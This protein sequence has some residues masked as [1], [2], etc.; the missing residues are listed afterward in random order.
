MVSGKHSMAAS[1]P[2]QTGVR[3][4][5]ALRALLRLPLRALY[6]QPPAGR[7]TTSAGPPRMAT[8]SIRPGAEGNYAPRLGPVDDLVAESRLSQLRRISCGRR[9]RSHGLGLDTWRVSRMADAT[10]I[11]LTPHEIQ[12]LVLVLEAKIWRKRRAH[13]SPAAE[14]KRRSKGIE[15]YG[16]RRDRDLYM[17]REMERLAAKL[18]AKLGGGAV[19][20]TEPC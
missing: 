12:V 4:P 13:A 10:M 16:D 6:S 8:L 2:A 3:G 5:G 7:L 17:M 15:P 1:L 14:A 20:T 19:P 18:R 11:D 9:R